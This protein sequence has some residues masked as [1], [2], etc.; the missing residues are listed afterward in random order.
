[1]SM[2]PLQAIGEGLSSLIGKAP[3]MSSGKPFL[4]AIDATSVIV[5]SILA[6]N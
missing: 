6:N 4:I 2:P 1:M 5:R 3:A